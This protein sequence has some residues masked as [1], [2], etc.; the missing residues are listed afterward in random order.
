MTFVYFICTFRNFCVFVNEAAFKSFET[1]SYKLKSLNLHNH[2]NSM[3]RKI[4]LRE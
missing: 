2:T 4:I 1:F 3:T